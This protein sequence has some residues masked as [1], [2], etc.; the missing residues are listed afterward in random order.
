MLEFIEENL[1]IICK[2]HGISVYVYLQHC[3][4][5]KKNVFYVIYSG[6]VFYVF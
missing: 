1:A 3:I 2:K 5:V 6:H 4:D